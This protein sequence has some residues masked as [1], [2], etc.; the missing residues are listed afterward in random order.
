MIFRDLTI[1]TVV[2]GERVPAGDFTFGNGIGSYATKDKAIGLNIR[3]RILSWVN[4]CF[5][6]INAGI[7]WI[8]RLGSKNQRTLL[9]ADLRRIILQSTGV[10]GIITFDTEVIGRN[11]I[12]NYSITTENSKSYIDSITLGV[13]NG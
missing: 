5:F 3:T 12:A 9:E 7:D 6:D 2:D 4:D 8:N 1:E 11:F 13:G 10:T